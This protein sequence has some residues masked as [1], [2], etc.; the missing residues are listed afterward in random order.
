MTKVFVS[1]SSIRLKE[2]EDTK[3]ETTKKTN[4]V[5]PITTGLKIHSHSANFLKEFYEEK[6]NFVR[7]I[8]PVKDVILDKFLSV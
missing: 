7:Q 4:D 6:T 2:N 5:S 8:H 1:P 3:A